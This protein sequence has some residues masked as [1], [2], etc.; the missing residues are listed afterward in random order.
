MNLLEAV[1]DLE[2]LD[3]ES[4]IYAV[5]PWTESSAVVV[6]REP[7]TGGVPENAQKLGMKYFLEIFIA[8]DFLEDW[9]ASLDAEPSLAE[10]CARLIDYAIH[11][12]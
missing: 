12:A 5:E 6:E 11:D 3:E 7:E 8:R 1:R 10:K 2:T 4:T 9:T